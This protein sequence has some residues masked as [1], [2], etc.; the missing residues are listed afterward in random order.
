VVVLISKAEASGPECVSC[1]RGLHSE[2]GSGT[3]VASARHIAMPHLLALWLNNV[4][5]NHVSGVEVRS[6]PSIRAEMNHYYV[7]QVTF[8]YKTD[9]PA[10]LILRGSL[11]RFII[12]DARKK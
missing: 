4:Q 3:P 2:K 11:D 1:V 9:Y 7:T 12:K 5:D 10:I 6:C 8:T